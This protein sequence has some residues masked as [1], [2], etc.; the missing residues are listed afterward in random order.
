MAATGPVIL[1]GGPTASGKS[2]L[3][4]RLAGELRGVIVNADSMQVYADLAIL[5]ARP[6]AEDEARLPHRLFGFLDAAVPCSAGIWH[7]HAFRVCREISDSGRVPILVGGTGLYL[8]TFRKGLASVPRIPE[9]VR[10]RVRRRLAG[11]GSEALHKELGRIDPDLAAAL[12]PSDGQRIARG[13][14][15]FEATGMMLSRWQAPPPEGGWSGP[16]LQVSLL[17]PRKAV[18]ERCE[19]RFDAMMAAGAL[20]EAAR[21]AARGLDP[22][23][24]ALKCLGVAS[25]IAHLEGRATLDRAVKEA[26]TATRRYAKRQFTWFRHQVPDAL[27]LGAFGFGDEAGGVVDKARR[28]LLTDGDH[29]A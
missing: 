16:L 13:V 25:L 15:V 6:S 29:S 23:L 4:A 3:A 20:Q 7:Q 14:E 17:P 26:K 10:V 22:S 9:D 19:R 27:A 18:M 11:E 24:P 2:D 1:L 5:T 12:A 8:R 21:L 28:F